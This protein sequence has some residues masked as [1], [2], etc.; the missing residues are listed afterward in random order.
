MFFGMI[1]KSIMID[2]L[3]FIGEAIANESLPPGGRWRR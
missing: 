3:G 1:L 2:K